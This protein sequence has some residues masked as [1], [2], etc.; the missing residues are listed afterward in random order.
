[1]EE[2]SLECNAFRLYVIQKNSVTSPMSMDEHSVS[3]NQRE[4]P[5]AFQT[6]DIFL[7]IRTPTVLPTD[8]PSDEAERESILT[9]LL[10][11][12]HKQRPHDFFDL[13]NHLPSQSAILN[14]DVSRIG[15]AYHF[16]SNLFRLI[17][18][19]DE[20]CRVSLQQEIDKLQVQ[21]QQQPS[22]SSKSSDLTS[23]QK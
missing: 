21:H 6:N 9:L 7:N 14:P 15:D 17:C 18:R 5:I 11:V 4:E 23:E 1:M 2:G 22:V 20:P 19:A 10:K 8:A 13:L 12:L 16:I 3:V